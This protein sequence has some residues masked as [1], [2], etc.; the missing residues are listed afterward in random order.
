MS[1]KNARVTMQ[2]YEIYNELVK[3]LMLPPGGTG[4]YLDLEE[5]AERG[6]YVKV[7]IT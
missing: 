5:N 2:M 1:R 3:D 4:S 6:V 7:R